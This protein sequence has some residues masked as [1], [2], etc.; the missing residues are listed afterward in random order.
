MYKCKACDGRGEVDC[1]WY[2]PI[3]VECPV[4]KSIGKVD[5]ITNIKWKNILEVFNK[6]KGY[7]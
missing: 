4:C 7:V 1:G 6:E 2:C 3:I 5:W